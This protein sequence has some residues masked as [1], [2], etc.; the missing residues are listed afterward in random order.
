MRF[1][2]KD[3]DRKECLNADLRSVRA[4]LPA[5]E[6]GQCNTKYQNRML[7]SQLDSLRDHVPQ[8]QRIQ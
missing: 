8:D 6:G 4:E 7:E 2:Y 1:T 3:K 5:K